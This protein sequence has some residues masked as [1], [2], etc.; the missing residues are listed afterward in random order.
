MKWAEVKSSKKFFNRA[1]SRKLWKTTQVRIKSF[2]TTYI[3]EREKN[4]DW[5]RYNLYE[6]LKCFSM[7]FLDNLFLDC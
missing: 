6:F 7:I 5:H 2:Q 4:S 1:T 3:N